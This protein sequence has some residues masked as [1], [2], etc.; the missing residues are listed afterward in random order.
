MHRVYLLKSPAD[1]TD[2]YQEAPRWRAGSC[3]EVCVLKR[4]RWISFGRKFG[5]TLTAVVLLTY[6]AVAMTNWALAANLPDTAAW[7]KGTFVVITSASAAWASGTAL[8]VLCSLVYYRLRK[9][10]QQRHDISVY[11]KHLLDTL[12]TP[13]YCTDRNFRFTGCN[14]EFAQLLRRRSESI[15]GRRLRELGLPFTPQ[16]M[17]TIEDYSLQTLQLSRSVR[18]EMPLADAGETREYLCYQSPLRNAGGKVIG[19]V[20]VVLDVTERNRHAAETRQAK[21]DAE[22]A[23]ADV[24]RLNDKLQGAVARASEM[25]EYA[26]AANLAKTEFLANMSHEIRTPLTAILGYTELLMDGEISPSEQ[27]E[28]LAVVHRNGRHLLGLINDILDLSKIE[29]GRLV[30]ETRPCSVPSVIADAVSTLRVRAIEKGIELRV[31]YATSVPE[32]VQLDD[33]RLRQILVNLVGNAVKFTSSGSVSVTT[34]HL[35]SWQQRGSAIR[36]EVRDTGIGIAP[37]KLA[38]IGEPF[39]QADASTSRQYGGTGLGLAIVRNLVE[40][41]GGELVVTS[42]EGQGSC[43]AFTLPTEVLSGTRMLDTPADVTSAPGRDGAGSDDPASLRLDGLRI[44]LAEDGP[45]NQVLIRT[46]LQRAGADVDLVDNGRSACHCAMVQPYHVVLMD[47]QMP[48]MDGYE[49]TRFLRANGNTRPIIALTAHAM[50]N[51]RQRCL[52]AG[53]SE[54]LTKPID[55][56]KLVQT[57]TQQVRSWRE[58]AAPAKPQKP[59]AYL[60]LHPDKPPPNEGAVFAGDAAPSTAAPTSYAISAEPTTTAARPVP[61]APPSVEPAAVHL[62]TMPPIRSELA[63]EVDLADVIDSFVKQLPHRLTEM[64]QAFA[65]GAH[66]ELTRLAHRLKGAGG[67]YGYPTLTTQAR[68]LEDA[69]RSGD[70]EAATLALARLGQ[71]VH[72]VVRGWKPRLEETRRA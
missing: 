65:A 70:R 54:Y 13:F 33:N 21:L 61:S 37:G 53:C 12:P 36:I 56:V 15:F 69:A 42:T 62:S 7:P 19:L 1:F 5:F 28:R 67:S 64:Q 46:L 40:K 20:G 17:R 30:L 8:V 16:Q 43:F 27:I 22:K 41:M 49:A 32:Q 50:S 52:D 25:A 23:L 2:V 31:D 35:P 39:Y 59:T 10:E 9:T 11:Y 29:A 71:T 68:E 14:P 24:S 60:P 48:Q 45:D 26:E 51:D 3:I 38:H 57:I 6:A 66:A 4:T 58:T 55:R 47:M 63:D 34:T 18:F 72:A 44:L